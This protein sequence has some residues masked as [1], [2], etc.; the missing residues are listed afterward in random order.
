MVAEAQLKAQ[1]GFLMWL[2]AVF[3][4]ILTIIKYLLK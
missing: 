2:P 3:E 1:N 4:P